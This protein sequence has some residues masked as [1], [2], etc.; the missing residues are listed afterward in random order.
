LKRIIILLV[1]ALA[2]AVWA[3]DSKI[4]VYT[5]AELEDAEGRSKPNAKELSDSVRDVT[6]QIS[7]R[8]HLEVSTA[9]AADISVEIWQRRKETRSQPGYPK[10]ARHED[11]W[12]DEKDVWHIVSYGLEAGRFEHYNEVGGKSWRSAAGELSKEVERWAK[13]NR[14]RLLALRQQ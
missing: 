6:K 5:F 3:E 10:Y 1:L 7:M 12:V 14:A 13:E 11:R 4:R 8:E 2:T 9:E